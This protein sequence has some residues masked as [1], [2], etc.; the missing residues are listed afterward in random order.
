MS[1]QNKAA[2]VG[3][4][5]DLFFPGQGEKRKTNQAKA[6]C[7]GCPVSQDC[8]SFTLKH[9]D[10]TSRHGIYGGLTQ[11]ERRRLFGTVPVESVA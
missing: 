11:D 10:P 9:E 7:K 6:I 8:L 1:W 2:C 4:P 5:L 3:M